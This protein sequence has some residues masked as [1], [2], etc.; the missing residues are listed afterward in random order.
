MELSFYNYLFWILFPYVTII[1]AALAARRE[2]PP[3]VVR[4]IIHIFGLITVSLIVGLNTFL[5]AFIIATIF[6]LLFLLLSFSGILPLYQFLVDKGTRD[7]E[8]K[9]IA[10]LNSMLTVLVG[11][12]LMM[13]FVENVWIFMA[14][15][16]SIA[17]GDGLGEVIGRT[18][19][20]HPYKIIRHK[21]IE[22]S[23]AVFLGTVIALVSPYL[24]A[25]GAISFGIIWIF[26][27]VALGVTILEALSWAFT[28]NITIP[29]FVALMLSLAT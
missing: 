24:L 4:K 3:W 26:L 13:I 14:S 19:G 20:H 5:D 27:F 18:L 1:I 21:T 6:S 22:G 28:D 29:L 11:L 10:Y 12:I 25:F 17:I 2:Y 23:I 9:N 7:G 15:M 16:L 8:S